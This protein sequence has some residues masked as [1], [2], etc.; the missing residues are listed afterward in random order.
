[1]RREREQ[2]QECERGRR[3]RGCVGE[4]SSL[5]RRLRMWRLCVL[6]DVVVVEVVV[7]V[8]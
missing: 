5:A 4:M 8:W 7:S 1:M 3:K 2:M 6:F